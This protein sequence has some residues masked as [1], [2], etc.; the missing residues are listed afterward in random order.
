MT[1]PWRKAFRDFWQ[2]R[3]R[4]ALV[5]LAIALGIFGFSTV[6]STYAILTRELD[7][8]YLATN[9]ASAT[10]RVDAIDDALVAAVL[11][12]HGVSDAEPRRVVT[13]RIKAGPM[14]WKGLTLFVVKD[15]GNIRVSRLVPEKGAWPPATGEILIE[16]DAFQVARVKIGD[17]VTVKTARGS[18]QPLRVT[19]S[20][21]DV[22]QAQAR[23]ENVVYGYIT[24][25]TLAA[26]GEEPTL[27]QLKILVAEN[28]FDE[29]H[30]RAVAEDVRKVIEAQ[31]HRVTR[32]DVPRPGKHPHADITGLLLLAMSSFGV[33]VL[34][35][36]GILVVN[37]L[38]ALMASQVRQIGVMKAIGGSSAQIG[39]IY[40]GQALLLGI[41]AT[42]VAI[43]AGRVGAR[44]FCRYMAVFLNFDISSFAVPAWVDGL[45]AAVGVVVPLLAAAYPV[46]KGS[47]ISVREA[48][49]DFGVS[50]NAFGTSGFDRALAGMGG[51]AR[52]VLLAIRN[53][54]RRRARLAL[55]VLTL[56]AG[57]TFFMA[58]LNVRAS[59]IAT[60]DALF[61]SRKYDLSV[62]FASMVSAEK[63]DR[64]VRKTPGILRWEGW[65]TT[66]GALPR[67]GESPAGGQGSVGDPH[68]AGSGSAGGLHGGGAVSGDRFP[69]FAVPAES[70]VLRLQI[71][72]GRDLQ[73]QDTDA[74]VINDALAAKAPQDEGGPVRD[75][76]NGAGA[77]DLARRRR[78][79][80][81]VVSSCG[82]RAPSLFP[83]ARPRGI[84][85]HH[86][87]RSR[88]GRLRMPRSQRQTR[89][90]AEPGRGGPVGSCDDQPGRQ[91]VR[92]RP[93][94]ADDL[95]VPD[96][97][98]RHPRRRRRPRTDDDHELERHGTAARNG[99]LARDRRDAAG[100]VAP[101]RG[102]GRLH[103]RAE[104]AA[105]RPGR[106]AGQSGYRQ[107]PGQGPVPRRPRL[108]FRA[109]GALRVAR[110]FGPAESPR[111]LLARLACVSMHRSGGHRL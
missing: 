110:R 59:L 109:A 36:S 14:E 4:T 43:P 48:L 101:R 67:P 68:A 62:S 42:L 104:L 2:E 72:E 32:V 69:I 98:V 111:E 39:R 55:T 22:G 102:R 20:V 95:R 97:H 106:V 53:S 34:L 50:R 25:D 87:P 47:G 94:H 65:I 96:R 73:K 23:M 10:L 77:D 35:L 58:A 15:Y 81:A 92:L 24:L 60:L 8:G 83:G 27:D 86:P 26:L 107:L 103:R 74:I 38:S 61:R 1:A 100:R 75:V 90:R 88:Q 16:R 99:R 9:P 63:I 105:R 6:L 13:G 54:F 70:K 56:A 41:A 33:F 28:R 57:G 91:P 49:A 71:L 31:G 51:W 84:G 44:V 76:S 30:I 79:A 21:H 82:L 108:L 29:K 5:V 37:L 78:R 52:P 12:G 11:S 46:L 3:T 66:E 7:K 17:T 80:G 64:A 40:F 18:E 45:A 89:P 93:A 85:Q 19:G